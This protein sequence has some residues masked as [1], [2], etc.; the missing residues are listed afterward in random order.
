ML[1]QAN[2]RTKAVYEAI[3]QQGEILVT[4]TIIEGLYI[5]RVV[6]AN[7]KTEAKYMQLAF[8]IFVNAT[9]N[10]FEEEIA[11]EAAASQQVM[12]KL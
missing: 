1:A 11:Q 9:E 10:H 2:A 8:D 4:N 12:A 3:Y 6:C 7:P 5:I